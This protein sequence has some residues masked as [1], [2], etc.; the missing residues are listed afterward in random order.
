MHR[1]LR[2]VS[3]SLVTLLA[4]A[5]ACDK[6]ATSAVSSAVPAATAAEPPLQGRRIEIKATNEGYSP[7]KVEVKK[8]EAVVLRFIRETKSE[9]L[10]EV[11][12]PS[13]K[14]KKALPM[15]T[16]VEIGIK[17]DKEGEIVFECGM[18]MLRGKIIVT[19]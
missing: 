17:P 5:S 11:Q 10:A 12:I 8:G 18:A 13:L 16:P 9:C 14:I 19:S 7:S 1:G 3:V 4:L 6:S 15:N 2:L